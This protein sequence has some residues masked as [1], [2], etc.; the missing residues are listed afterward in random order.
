MAAAHLL[1]TEPLGGMLK[2]IAGSSLAGLVTMCFA[3]SAITWGS[4]P[5]CAT[6]ASH[7]VHAPAHESGSSHQHASG[8]DHQPA[9]AQ[10]LVHLCCVQLTTPADH[11]SAPVRIALP[12]R[13][14]A[15]LLVSQLIPVRPA[16]T[17]PFAHAPPTALI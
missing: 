6:S 8:T 4:M 1:G 12:G 3:Y 13:A 11:V 17:L 7:S 5:G 9:Q 15:L 2:R 10:C 14:A 16:H